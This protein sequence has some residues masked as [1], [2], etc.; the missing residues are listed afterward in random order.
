MLRWLIAALI[1]LSLC[2]CFRT[3]Q[4]IPKLEAPAPPNTPEGYHEAVAD[5][6]SWGVLTTV[7][8]WCIAPGVIALTVGTFFFPA[9]KGVGGTLLGIGFLAAVTPHILRRWGDELFIP[10]IVCVGILVGVGTGLLVYKMVVQ[11]LGRRRLAAIAERW[12][13]STTPEEAARHEGAYTALARTLNP[14]VDHG[15]K[16][17]LLSA[18]DFVAARVS[19]PPPITS[20]LDT[21]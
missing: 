9:L 8:Y 16:T 13:S 1:V 11:V 12:S 15:F 21:V 4:R 14:K 7:A 10:A 5:A 18:P 3:C 6:A 19:L 2:G 17:G 20:S